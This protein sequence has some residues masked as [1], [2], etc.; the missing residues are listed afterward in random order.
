MKRALVALLAVLAVGAPAGAAPH[1]RELIDCTCYDLIRIATDRPPTTVFENSGQNIFDVSLRSKLVVYGGAQGRLYVSPF[2]VHRPRLLDSRIARWAVFSPDG[3]QIAYGAIGCGLC[4]V[5]ADGSNRHALP[6]GRAGGPAAWRGDGRRL[7]FVIYDSADPEAG[8]VATATPDGRGVRRLARGKNF[9]GGTSIG[10]KL[11]WASRVNRIAYLSGLPTRVHVAV[12]GRQGQHSVRIG[13]APVWSPDGQRL[14]IGGRRGIAVVRADGT[15][16]HALD[17]QAVDPYGFG[18][19]WSP[20]GRRIA[21]ARYVGGRYQL[22]IAS[23]D[24]THRRILTTEEQDM[25]IGPAYWSPDG[26]TLVYSRLLSQ[27]E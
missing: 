22:A 1:A 18:V 9:A 2:G 10:A 26:E 21:Y 17:P 13:V 14:A 20:R 11:A 23:P 3:R 25:E 16:A 19:S 6:L 8:W 15:H 12:D 4:I 7:A 27:G 24:G 5:G